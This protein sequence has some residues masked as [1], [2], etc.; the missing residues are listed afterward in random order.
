MDQQRGRPVLIEFWDFC[1]PN[2]IRTLPYVRSWDERYGPHG[3]QVVGV[4]T[5]GFPPSEDP[6]A[7]GQAVDRLGVTYPVVVDVQREIW[8]RYGNL[9]WPARYLFDQRGMLF[10]Q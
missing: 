6:E 2:S 9:G 7:V 10:E 1:R 8:E 4:H 5:S 3:L